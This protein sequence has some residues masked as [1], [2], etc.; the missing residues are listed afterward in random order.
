MDARLAKV[1]QRK[2]KQE[3]PEVGGDEKLSIDI[4]D[5]NFEKEGN[6]VGEETGQP[7]ALI[8]GS[9]LSTSSGRGS[10]IDDI[11]AQEVLKA[12]EKADEEKRA[13][14]VRPWD[15]GKSECT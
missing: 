2:L 11:I 8:A 13:K 15:R 5:F 3:V 10:S 6:K 1:R 14:H 7:A 4:A 9:G 12:R